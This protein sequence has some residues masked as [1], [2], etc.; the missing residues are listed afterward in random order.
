MVRSICSHRPG[1]R[2]VASNDRG[3][4]AAVDEREWPTQ[5]YLFIPRGRSDP[6]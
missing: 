3:V 6:R 4:I 5:D 1:L 2:A